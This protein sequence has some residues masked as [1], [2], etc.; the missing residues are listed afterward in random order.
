MVISDKDHP[1]YTQAGPLQYITQGGEY[2]IKLDTTPARQ[3]VQVRANQ[4]MTTR[5]W[6]ER[7]K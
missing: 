3:V 7:G 2:V 6:G 4:A 5:E 1:E